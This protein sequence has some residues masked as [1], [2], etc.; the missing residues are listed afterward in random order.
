MNR[1]AWLLSMTTGRRSDFD[2]PKRSA[3][4]NEA[5][6]WPSRKRG[7][8]APKGTNRRCLFSENHRSQKN[9]TGGRGSCRSTIDSLCRKL[10]NATGRA[11]PVDAIEIRPRQSCLQGWWRAISIRKS[12]RVLLSRSFA[13]PMSTIDSLC[14]KLFNATGRARPVDARRN[15]SAPILL[16]WSVACHIDPEITSSVAQQELRTPDVHNRLTLSK[17]IQRHGP[18]KACRCEKKSVRANLACMV[19][20][21]PYR[22]GNHLECGSAGASHSRCPQSTFFVE[23][24]STPRTVQG[25]LMRA[26]SVR[27]NLACKVGGV[28]Y[29]T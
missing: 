2:S 29:R 10:F 20:G 15:P 18:C 21:V 7:S 28:P 25:L 5:I 11:R 17:T 1:S 4:C 3:P 14:R 22:S 27:A 19:G 16:V 23:N 24:Y 13:L 26:K 6:A 8:N 9:R 12:H